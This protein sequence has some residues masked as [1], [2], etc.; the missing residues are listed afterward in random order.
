MK[1]RG[2]GLQPHTQLHVQ[3]DMTKNMLNT[4]RDGLS[5]SP[6][7]IVEN[8]NDIM[9]VEGIEREG[10]EKEF[11]ETVGG[12]TFIAYKVYPTNRNVVFNGK[13][14]NGIDWQF[15]KIDGCYINVPNIELNEEVVEMIKRLYGQ[16]GNWKTKWREKIGEYKVNNGATE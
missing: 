10:D 15:S 3:H 11:T 16:F 8:Q 6:G 13:L 2:K 4:I 5:I 1:R 14:D 7:V 12:G 9:D